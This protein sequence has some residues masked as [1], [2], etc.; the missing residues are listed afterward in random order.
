MVSAAQRP[1]ALVAQ[2]LLR[3]AQAAASRRA[4]Q[5]SATPRL[6]VWDKAVLAVMW[7]PLGGLIFPPAAAVAAVTT[8]VAADVAAKTGRQSVVRGAAV[9]AIHR[10]QVRSRP[11]AVQRMPAIMRIL[12]TTPASA[13]GVE[14]WQVGEMVYW[15][16]FVNESTEF[17][18]VQ[19]AKRQVPWSTCDRKS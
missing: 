3:A 1:G 10:G 4:V 16:S 13:Q 19:R 17:G 8:A 12:I 2:T 18:T 5:C 14:L 9:Q 7:F 15:S 6:G 11:Q